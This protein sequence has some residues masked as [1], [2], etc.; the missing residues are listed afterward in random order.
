MSNHPNRSNPIT[1]AMVVSLRGELTQT[2]AARLWRCSLRTVQRWESG[3]IKPSFA[4]WV[5]MQALKSSRKYLGMFATA[6]LAFEAYQ[7]YSIQH[8][9]EFK[10]GVE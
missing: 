7:A 8:Q 5:G 9:G 6:E 10:R 4:T 3:E 1:P 2:A